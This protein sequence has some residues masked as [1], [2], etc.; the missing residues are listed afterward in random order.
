MT[1]REIKSEKERER[2][3][4]RERQRERERERGRMEGISP[5]KEINRGT[6]VYIK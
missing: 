2:E 1:E 5:E 4:E 6:Q 3:R